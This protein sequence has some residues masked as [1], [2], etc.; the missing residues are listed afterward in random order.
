MSN[1]GNLFL[2]PTAIAASTNDV[3]VPPYVKVQVASIRHFLVEDVRTAR[4]YL[5]G[6][7]IFESIEPLTFSVLNKDTRAEELEALFAEA[8]NGADLGVLSES[9]CP[10]IAD[11]GALA[12]AYAHAKGIRVIPLVGPSSIIMALMASGL[13]GQHFAFHGYLP[14]QPKEASRAIGQYEKESGIRNQTQ[15]FIETPYR[16]NNLFG[17]L[18]RNLQ[19]E[20]RLCLAVDI[21]GPNEFILTQAVKKW[22][23]QSPELKKEPAVFLFLA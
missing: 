14:I 22:R 1:K 18:I 10:G 15:I 13:N 19:P 3:T 4:R 8:Y 16:N 23:Q 21:T 9:G 20:T 12:V 11:P 17:N 7:K 5:S 2:I 6:L